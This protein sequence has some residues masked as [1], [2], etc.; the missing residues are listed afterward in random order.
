MKRIILSVAVVAA[1]AVAGC[2]ATSSGGN[3]PHRASKSTAK[4]EP[5][6]LDLTAL[7]R[8]IKPELRKQLTKVGGYPVTIDSLDC[9][10]KDSST[11]KCFA[12]VHDSTGSVR[13]G[14]N[15]DVDQS[16]GNAIWS[17]EQ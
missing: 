14:I 13:L 3:D 10:E 7:E 1:V 11:A 8:Q 6:K 2:G 5:V 15:A 4:V 17:V 16:T 12:G 9:I